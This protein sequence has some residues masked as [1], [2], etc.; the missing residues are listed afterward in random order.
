MLQKYFMV[1]CNK[2]PLGTYAYGEARE[3]CWQA[4]SSIIRSFAVLFSVT[5]ETLLEH[6]SIPV[7]NS[8]VRSK[9]QMPSR[10]MSFHRTYDVLCHC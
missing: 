6:D 7:N 5:D 10:Y 2:L 4:S 8:L 3:R 9:E 1:V